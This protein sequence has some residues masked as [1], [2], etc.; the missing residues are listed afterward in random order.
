MRVNLQM[1]PVVALPG[2]MLVHAQIEVTWRCNWRCVHCYQDDH[3]VETLTTANLR[4]LFQD[5]ARVGAMHLIVTGGEPLMR[6]DILE[7][8]EEARANGLVVTLYTNGHKIDEALASRL[9]GLIGVAELSVLA[10]DDETHD[11]LTRVRGSSQRTWKA[12]DLLL[13]NGVSVALKTPVLRPAYPTLRLIEAKAMA[14][15]VSWTAD[16]E[17]S[18]SYAGA[19][20]PLAYRLSPSEM[21]TFY[22]DF[23]QFSKEAGFNL[24]A[25]RRGGMCLA[26]RNYVFIDA[27][28]NVYPCLNFKS[29]SDALEGR[30]LKA[31]AKL[32]NILVRSFEEI[33]QESPFLRYIQSLQRIDFGSCGGCGS[34]DQ[35]SPCMALNYEEHGD[36]LVTSSR[37]RALHTAMKTAMTMDAK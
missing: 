6:R 34:S 12:V 9:S 24:D 14:R 29:G 18:P 5:L 3:F 7:I 37:V 27:L 20:F 23:P 26:G 15:G 8:L 32:G 21:A 33:W 1:L 10:G 2:D 35:C 19:D 11:R 17:I 36:V 30:G 4:A 31:R 28:G 13:A 25:G 16:P 22:R